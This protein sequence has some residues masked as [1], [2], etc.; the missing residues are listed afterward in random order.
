MDNLDVCLT[1]LDDQNKLNC[2]KKLT[3][4]SNCIMNPANNVENRF[5]CDE[6]L[7]KYLDCMDKYSKNRY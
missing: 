3:K 1:Y 7:K 4:W 6:L 5:L 2:K